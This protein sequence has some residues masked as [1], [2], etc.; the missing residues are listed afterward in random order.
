VKK[1]LI[2]LMG[3]DIAKDAAIAFAVKKPVGTP[4][5][6]DLVRPSPMVCTTLPMAPALTNSP[7][8]T[9]RGFSSRSLYMIE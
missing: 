2:S 9:W 3:A 6:P 8:L 7:A 5:E 4:V 1:E